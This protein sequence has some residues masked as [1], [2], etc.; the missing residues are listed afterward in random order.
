VN[1]TNYAQN[2]VDA[3]T[4]NRWYTAGRISTGFWFKVD[5]AAPQYIDKL[6]LDCTGYAGQQVQGYHVFVS[7]DGT[8]WGTPVV[9]GTGAGNVVTITMPPTVARYV[10]VVASSDTTA[11]WSLVQFNAYTSNVDGVLTVRANANSNWAL[12]YNAVRNLSIA[13]NASMACRARLGGLSSVQMM[14]G[15]A[16]SMSEYVGWL[17]DA[18]VSPNWAYVTNTVAGGQTWTPLAAVPGDTL[19]HE[20]SVV[21]VGSRVD[22]S[23]DGALLGSYTS[24][25]TTQILAPTVY[26][27]STTTAVKEG[28]VDY[29]ELQGERE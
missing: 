19:W 20:F 16:F 1:S 17:Y 27:A 23:V 28:Y 13:K 15:L 2:A 9:S 7:L 10:M 4:A 6:V 22:F 25:L 14:V 26:V 11:S 21:S 8:N 24:N 18:A 3:S 5:F 12:S 29:I